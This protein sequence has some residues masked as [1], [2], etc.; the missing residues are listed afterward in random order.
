MNLYNLLEN[1]NKSKQDFK[2]FLQYMVK[3]RSQ[4][5]GMLDSDKENF[6]YHFDKLP[7]YFEEYTQLHIEKI[8]SALASIEIASKRIKDGVI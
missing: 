5:N 6:L 2:Q 8:I 1:R 3:E 7:Q 4:I